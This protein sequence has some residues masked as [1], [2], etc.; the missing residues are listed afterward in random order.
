M[1]DATVSAFLGFL[2]GWA[3]VWQLF[4]LF[5]QQYG[6]GRANLCVMSW[7]VP[8]EFLSWD[9]SAAMDCEFRDLSFAFERNCDEFINNCEL[10]SELR[11]QRCVL[12]HH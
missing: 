11:Y 6:N 4:D 9:G 1:D 12:D 3:I 5:Q 10:G 7:A 2:Y 8:C